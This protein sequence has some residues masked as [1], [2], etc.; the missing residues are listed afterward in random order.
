M[1][2]HTYDFGVIGNCAFTAHIHKNTNIVWMCWPRFDSSFIFGSLVDEEKGG[3]FSVIPCEPNAT[4]NQ[5][6]I[7]NTNVLCTEVE[8]ADGKFLVTDFAPRFYQNDRYYKPL[9]MVRKIEPIQG[10]PRIKVECEPRGDYGK[11]VPEQSQGSNHIRFLGL[12]GNV[13]LT[14]NIPLTYVMEDEAFVLNETKY[15]VFTFGPPLEAPL[16]ATV[17]TFLS[18]TINY[19]RN[20]VKS[21]SIYDFYQSQVIRSMLALKIHQYE[22]TGAILAA[23][24]TSLPEAPGTGRNWDYR[25]CWMRDTYYTLTAF[26]SIGHFEELEKYFQYILNTSATHKGRLQP[27]YGI[28]ESSNL[29]EEIL[30]LKGYMGNGPVRI[31]NDAYT[32]IQNDVYG[33]VLVSLLPLYTDR[34]FIGKERSDSLKLVYQALEMIENTMDEPD[35]GLWEFRNLAQ[36]HCYTYLFHWAGSAAA[37]KIAK[38]NGDQ[39]MG[40]KAQKLMERSAKKIEECYVPSKK[41]YAQAIGVERMDA[42]TLQLIMMNYFQGDTK[43]ANDHLM[44]LEAELKGKGGLFY[45]YK[46]VDD[47]GSP[48]TTFLICAF[49]Y[50]EALACVGRLD[51][52]IKTFE[53]TIAYA[54]HVGLLSE[55]VAE[56]DGSMWG[57]FPQAY[58]HVGLLNA[59]NRI[60]R[61]LDSPSF[62]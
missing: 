27:L 36:K 21:T 23:T 31:G 22:D 49:W 46:H 11:I 48:E 20:W 19:W 29:I 39:V 13:R 60:A 59:A 15:L 38:H 12:D 3:E 28:S 62:L 42:S 61:K 50:V 4:F 25:F 45:R 1:N 14:T 47:F 58:S 30:P 35:A 32:H 51:E 18:R 55:D 53:N 54:N 56:S 34:R 26:N 10:N 7:E 40:V 24:T 41:G 43:R 8:A 37:V 5:Y 57:N 9:M 17:E 33:Q 44:A 52:A 2:R 16:V 6:Y